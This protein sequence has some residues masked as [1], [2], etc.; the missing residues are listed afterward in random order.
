MATK[1]RFAFDV[2]VC[3]SCVIAA[4]GVQSPTSAD[5]QNYLDTLGVVELNS[6]FPSSSIERRVCRVCD[7]GTTTNV[8][9]G[10]L[11]R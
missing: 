10:T 1:V 6:I 11:I 5:W 7:T 9:S 8:V 3:N 4:H 2:L